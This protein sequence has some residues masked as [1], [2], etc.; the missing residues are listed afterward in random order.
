MIFVWER[1]IWRR[2]LCVQVELPHED[3]TLISLI[4]L[5]AS[6][7]VFISDLALDRLSAIVAKGPENYIHRPAAVT[8]SFRTRSL[9]Q[10]MQVLEQLTRK[11]YVWTF[12]QRFRSP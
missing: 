7:R 12:V 11:G 6:H 3:H 4:Q 10:E 5:L 8:I 1:L 9:G 2:E